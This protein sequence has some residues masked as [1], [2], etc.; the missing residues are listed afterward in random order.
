MTAAKPGRG[1]IIRYSY[2]WADEYGRGQ[3]DGR[4]D[5]PV[6]VAAISS[7]EMLRLLV[8]PITHA[9]I[10]D[11]S[12]GVALPQDVKRRLRLDDAES[13]IVTTE[14]NGFTWPGP[15]IRML[16]DRVPR[17]A[18]YGRVPDALRLR[19]SFLPRQS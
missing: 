8:L 9:R 16:P 11:P 15:D 3:K 6:L 12:A 14:A 17:T 5:R 13:W 4:K 18:V 2:L 1:D 19:A 7:S 10:S